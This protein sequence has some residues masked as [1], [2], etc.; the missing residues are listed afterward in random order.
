MVINANNIKPFIGESCITDHYSTYFINRHGKY[1][2]NEE[3]T[4]IKTITN[5]NINY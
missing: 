4:N 3:I 2:N 1:K 5:I